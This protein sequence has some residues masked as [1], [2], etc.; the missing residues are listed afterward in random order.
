MHGMVKEKQNIFYAEPVITAAVSE[1]KTSKQVPRTFF[2][3][4]TDENK[5]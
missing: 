4:N 2:S 5:T 3:N 1:R